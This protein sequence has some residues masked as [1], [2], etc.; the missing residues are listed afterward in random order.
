LQPQLRAILE[1]YVSERPPRQLLFP[2]QRAGAE[3]MI[4]DWRK[5]LDAVVA[6]AGELYVMVDGHRRRAEPGNVR[7]K[8]F[9]H[10]YCA[11]RL[12]SLD[13]GKPVAVFTVSRE[14]GHSSTTMVEDV[15]SH[16]GDCDSAA[17]G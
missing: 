6:R 5:A 11:T 13:G 9:R 15:Y 10:T 3:R 8:C 4:T 2:S 12:Q 16:L 7:S 17:K 1:R 14:L